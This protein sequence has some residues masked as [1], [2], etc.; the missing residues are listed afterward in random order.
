MI[1]FYV[2]FAGD[3]GYGSCYFQAGG[4]GSWGEAV[5]QGCGVQEFSAFRIQLAV[6]QDFLGGQKG[7][8]LALAFSLG[9]YGA[10]YAGADF[11]CGC[12][13]GAVFGGAGFFGVVFYENSQ[14]YAV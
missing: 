9:F 13:A 12:E 7:V 5:T 1:S 2:F 10:G 8:F 3:V 11:F 6:V 14:V 4:D